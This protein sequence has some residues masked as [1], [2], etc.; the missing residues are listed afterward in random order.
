VR[1]ALYA[2]IAGMLYLGIFPN[3]ALNGASHAVAN[4][5]ASKALPRVALH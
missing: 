2:C 3:S 1:F 4:L 5:G